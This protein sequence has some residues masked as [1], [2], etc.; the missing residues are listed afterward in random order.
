MIVRRFLAALAAVLGAL[1]PPALAATPEKPPVERELLVGVYQAPPW[2]IKNPKGEW[3]GLTVDL[4]KELAGDLK[5]RYRFVEEP[6]DTILDGVDKGRLDTSAGPVAVTLERERELDFTHGY[7]VSGISIAVVRSREADR[8]L[9]VVEALSTPTAL[10]LYGGV[11]ILIFVAG[12]AIWLLE[13][14][15]NAMFAGRPLQGLGSGFWFSA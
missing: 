8:W 12:A 3:S 13:R 5:L 14:R 1:G 7:V 2:S 15:R 9:T 10:R 11:V 4:W 6:P